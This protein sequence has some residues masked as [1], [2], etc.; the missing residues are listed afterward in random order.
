MP[1]T[2]LGVP[3]NGMFNEDSY[4]EAFNYKNADTEPDRQRIE[5]EFRQLL[6]ASVF[7]IEDPKIIPLAMKEKSSTK[8][9][10]Q[11]F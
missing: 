2:L 3:D 4:V 7:N 8:V 6:E 11:R 10:Q 1:M 9:Q 5:R